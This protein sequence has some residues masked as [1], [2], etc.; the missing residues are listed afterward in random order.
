MMGMPVTGRHVMH[1]AMHIGMIK[2]QKII[3]LELN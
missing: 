3:F 1:E 2:Q